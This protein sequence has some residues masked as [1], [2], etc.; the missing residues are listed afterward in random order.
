MIRAL[1]SAASGMV[2]QQLNIDNV[3]NN[4]ANANTTGLYAF[5]L[6]MPSFLIPI[7]FVR[8]P[9]ILF[10]GDWPTVVMAGIAIAAGSSAWT[11]MISGYL[12]T[13]LN[14][15]ERLMFGAVAV[16]LI[17][18]PFGDVGRYVSLVAFVALLV[19]GWRARLL[20]SGKPATAGE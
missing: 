3:A 18:V 15:V 4:L 6:G 19:W 7:A 2:A 16:V 8:D 9:G 1:F 17:L 20:R 13:P 11:I 14:L 10:V 5:I 12:T